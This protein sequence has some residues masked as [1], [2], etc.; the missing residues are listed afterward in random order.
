MVV[1]A[2]LDIQ[3]LDIIFFRV[4]QSSDQICKNGQTVILRGISSMPLTPC[5]FF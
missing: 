3:L 5:M 4:P 2:D 1:V